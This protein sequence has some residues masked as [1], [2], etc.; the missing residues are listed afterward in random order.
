MLGI[1]VRD[2]AGPGN[3]TQMAHRRV[4]GHSREVSLYRNSFPSKTVDAF[5]AACGKVPAS[6][7][8]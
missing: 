8:S 1:Q 3:V 7:L 6:T 2:G 5:N 4:Q